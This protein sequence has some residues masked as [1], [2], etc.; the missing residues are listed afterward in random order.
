MRLLLYSF[1][2]VLAAGAAAAQPPQPSATVSPKVLFSGPPRVGTVEIFGN[3]KLDKA[4]ILS[5]S[6]VSVGEPLTHSRR[7]MEEGLEK[8]P[9]VIQAEAKGY[10]CLGDDV[11]L[12]IG[13]VEN[14]ARP[15]SLHSPPTEDLALPT[16]I[17]L[18]YQR[19]LRALESAHERGVTGE[20]YTSGYPLSED[21]E[22]RR[23][24]E[25]LALIV[26]PY[27]EDLGQVLR[28]SSDEPTRAAAAYILAYTR[29]KTKAE[30][31]LQ[32]ALRDFDPDVR[33]NAIRSLEFIQQSLASEPPDE[34]GRR[35]SVSATWFIEML[36]SASFDDRLEASRMLVKLAPRENTAVL[37]QLEER[38]L[39]SLIEMAQWKVPEHAFSAYVLLGR[40]AGLSEAEIEKSFRENRRDAVMSVIRE[41][42]KARKRFLVF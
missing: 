25:T 7:E 41:R 10:C 15:F 22:A 38:T 27:V 24:Q 13:V 37:S 1:L 34:D 35:K 19:L 29:H 14:G 9:N 6:G 17:D 32:Y 12:Y 11:V 16:K 42:T 23:S 20:S 4:K 30:E 40:I 2:T 8:D 3:Q 5:L 39:P 26:D 28:R 36:Q 21:P 18:V 31:H 33:L